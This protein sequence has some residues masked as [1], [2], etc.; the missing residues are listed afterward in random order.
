VVPAE[1]PARAVGSATVHNHRIVHGVTPLLGG[2]RYSL[3]LMQFVCSQFW[4]LQFV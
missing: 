3:F 4:A 1:M 2:V